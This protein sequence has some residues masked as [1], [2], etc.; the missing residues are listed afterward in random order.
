M[1]K[2]RKQKEETANGLADKL[3][4]ALS[5]ILISEQGV[6]VHDMEKLRREL[7]KVNGELSFCKKTLLT[8]AFANADIKLPLDGFSGNVGIAFSYDDEVAAAKTAYAFGRGHE[9][10]KL[11]AGVLHGNV[12]PFDTV[13]ML[14][15]LPTR[16]ELLAQLVGTVA[17]PMRGFTSAIAGPLRGFVLAL[18]RIQQ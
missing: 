15:T 3:R 4:R 16:R 18:S 11:V 8:R 10:F 13:E 7:K 9:T 12:I 1:P 6:T 2:T 14:A 17:S 5:L